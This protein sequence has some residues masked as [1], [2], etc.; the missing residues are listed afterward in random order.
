M[1]ALAA[2]MGTGAAVVGIA[3]PSAAEVPPPPGEGDCIGCLGVK[4]QLL[5]RCTGSFRSKDAGIPVGCVSSQDDRPEVFEAPWQ[6]PEIIEAA[7][8][9]SIPR[10]MAELRQA[11]LKQGGRIFKEGEDGRYLRVEFP[12]ELPLLGPDVDDVEW[13]FAPDDTIVQ[14]RAERRSGRGD[15]GENRRRLEEIRKSLGW[16]IIAVLRNRKRAF[17]F[18]ESP[19]DEFGP[20][21]YEQLNGAEPTSEELDTMTRQGTTPESR[22]AWSARGGLLAN[23][24]LGIE[25]R[26]GLG[27]AMV[28]DFLRARCDPRLQICE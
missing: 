25:N 5:A 11:V 1:S 23:D 2:G 24:D 28:R 14:F 7:S 16:Q 19:F 4:D 22:Q 17:F 13:Y 26:D 21:L 20:S 3:R 8:G 15:F 9:K 10:Y 27:D 18:F 6:L 12:V